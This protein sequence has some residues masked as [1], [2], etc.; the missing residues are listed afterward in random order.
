MEH[1]L[2]E[3]DIQHDK[4]RVVFIH[5]AKTAG[6]TFNALLEPLVAGMHAYP[7]YG[8]RKLLSTEIEDLRKY[9]FFSG[10]FSYQLFT[11]IFPEGFIGLTFLREPVSRT[12]SNF[13]F[14]HELLKRDE[15]PELSKYENELEQL[16][17]M[18]FIELLENTELRFT[19]NLTDIQTR[20]LGSGAEKPSDEPS[21]FGKLRNPNQ[22]EIVVTRLNLELAKTRLVDI[23]F[24]GITE[25]FQDSL[26]LLSYTFGW[27]PYLNKVRLNPTIDK[28][29]KIDINV[30][31]HAVIREK[32]AFDLELY[33]FGQELFENRFNE[34]TQTLLQRY[35]TKEQATL[36]LPLPPDVMM[37][38]LEQH[39]IA[40]RD[41]RYKRFA[42]FALGNV[43]EYVPS[44]SVEGPFGW[45]PLEGDGGV[46][47]MRWSG[48]GLQ[49]G[50]DLPCPSGKNI[51]IS[52]R[53]LMAIQPEVMDGLA[54]TANNVPVRLSC[55]Q[56]PDGSYIFTGMLP[57]QTIVGPFVRLVFSVP[58]V[59]APC[60]IDP[61]NA[62]SR[63]LGV[64]LNWVKL[65]S[66]SDLAHLAIS[67]KLALSVL[68][69]K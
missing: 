18:S 54:L 37:T 15:I 19:T 50:F 21:G 45:Y 2:Q 56:Q 51:Q 53:I 36:K 44:M 11:T 68:G 13:K 8:L 24:L 4:D 63:L 29:E 22:K 17:K 47:P 59:V 6:T 3:I 48:P 30:D 20:F 64:L 28:G 27:R 1:Y 46:P 42:P 55:E 57:S 25:R 26:F 41:Q 14:F 5:L 16:R 52:F 67:F 23:A 43:Y 58:K 10:H 62:D 34:M 60:S 69:K 49:S 12:I 66:V 9:H 33:E 32:V 7:E 35:G 65:F 38:L 39:F 40:R 31:T 61:N